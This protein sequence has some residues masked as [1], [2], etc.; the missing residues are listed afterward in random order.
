MSNWKKA[1]M[2]AAGSRGPTVFGEEY[3]GGYYAG[4][5][6]QGGVEYYI[7]VAPKS[8]GQSSSLQWYESDR[9][10]PAATATINNGA[11]SSASMNISGYPAAQFCEGLS[12]NGY[13][14]WY[15][16]A[17]DELEL[18][19]R[20]L[21]PTTQANVV[22]TRPFRDITIN[23]PTSPGYPE[24]DDSSG[25][26]YGLNRSSVPSGPAYTAIDPLQTS[27]AI[28]QSGGSEAFDSV[29]YL[30]SSRENNYQVWIQYFDT[31]W[32]DDASGVASHRVRAVRREPV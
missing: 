14:D 22:D 25:D 5:I 28:F 12:I 1:M 20:N 26:K 24:F 29:A 27:A 6:M 32:Q 18:C 31:G 16:P 7:I 8:G 3:G 19:Y 11:A 13:T 4:N 2:A 23:N 21:K 15:L 9:V 30:T 17:R 10:S